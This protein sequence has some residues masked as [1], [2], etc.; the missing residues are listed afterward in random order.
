MSHMRYLSSLSL[1]ALLLPALLGNVACKGERSSGKK[2]DA[3]KMPSELAD[4][5]GNLW[6]DVVAGWKRAPL[7]LNISA[8]GKTLGVTI[9]APPHYLLESKPSSAILRFAF[10]PSSGNSFLPVFNIESVFRPS[11]DATEAMLK[12]NGHKVMTKEGG[13]GRY[14]LV[15]ETKEGSTIVI[16][17]RGEIQCRAILEG[18]VSARSIAFARSVCESLTPR[19]AASRAN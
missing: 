19:D 17:A 1:V 2:P 18:S 12:G 10:K 3:P 7:D 14:T 5:P 4:L 11:L 15:S 8:G 13:Q 6:L 16:A 9:A